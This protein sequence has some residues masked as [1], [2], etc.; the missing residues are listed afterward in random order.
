MLS[1]RQFWD[2]VPFIWIA[3][4]V[5]MMAL[6][7]SFALGADLFFLNGSDGQHYSIMR[8]SK[9]GFAVPPS[10][11]IGTGNSGGAMH[12]A[13]PS[14]FKLSSGI[15]RV[16]ASRYIGGK[17]S[18]IAI[19]DGDGESFTLRGV[20]LAANA[21]EPNGIG[22]AQL[23]YDGSDPRPY[24]LIYAV[25]NGSGTGSRFDLADSVDGLAF[26]RQDTVLTASEPFEAAGI[27]PSHVMQAS[28]GTWVLTYSAY[29]TLASCP[30]V[31]ATAATS[32]GP[33]V[34]KRVIM[35]PNGSRPTVT[36]A[37][38]LTSTATLL[39]GT[40]ALGE[41]HVL[42]ALPGG[43]SGM[44]LIVALQQV[45]GVI[46]FDHPILGDYTSADLVHIAASKVDPSYIEQTADG[47]RGVFT[48]FGHFAGVTS[49][50]TFAVA[51][52]SLD[53]PWT[54]SSGIP[55][56]PWNA[57]TLLSAENPTPLIVVVQ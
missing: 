54:I 4:I 31:V 14:A 21:A 15:E 8:Y 25:R 38:R 55:F 46:Y 57:A 17:W 37:R 5:G 47:W 12:V 39:S 35:S 19:W 34:N 2:S 10:P 3:V 43:G 9:D 11:V 32:N 56:S 45:D 24:K 23:Y 33:F 20:A 52:P 29:T 22:P 30:A 42:R 41:P 1:K 28:D 40:V 6:P 44:E 13:W 16:Y 49:E 18:D 53:G 51:S 26:T 50:Y 7:S 36:I 48:G 27:S